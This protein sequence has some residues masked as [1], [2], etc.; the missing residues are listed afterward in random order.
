MLLASVTPARADEPL[1]GMWVAVKVAQ[2]KAVTFEAPANKPGQYVP[3]EKYRTA[4]VVGQVV[5][6]GLQ[7]FNVSEEWRRRA[8]EEVKKRLPVKGAEL[9][10]VLR[11]WNP[12]FC[13]AAIGKVKRFSYDYSCDILLRT[14]PCMPPHQ[15]VRP[16]SQ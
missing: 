8:A 2:C 6:A 15:L 7:P 14:G 12:P 13:E 11:D 4:Q 5:D 3:G 9:F 10:L 16:D 1:V